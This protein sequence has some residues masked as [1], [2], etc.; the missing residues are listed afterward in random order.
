MTQSLSLAGLSRMSQLDFELAFFSSILQHHPDFLEALRAHAN[1]LRGRADMP[2]APMPTEES[3]R[4][5]PGIRSLITTSLAA[6]PF[7]ATWNGPSATS[8]MRWSPV[9]G[10][11]GF[12]ARTRTWPPSAKIRV[13]ESFSG[14]SN[15]VNLAL[16][17]M[18]PFVRVTDLHKSFG[19]G[20]TAV[21][22]L[23]KLSLDLERGE[24]V[25]LLGKSGSG[26]STLLNLL[27][28]LDHPT[29][30]SILVDGRE[31]T[32][33]NSPQ[34]ASYRL[35]HV[36]MVFQ[37][38]HL[39]TNR[40][41]L[42]NVELPMLL[43]GIPKLERRRAAADALKAVGM[44]E[45]TLHWP[46]TLSGGERQ[47]VAIARA[48]VNRPALVLADEPTGNLDSATGTV[49]MDLLIGTIQSNCSTLVLV[50][51][52]EDLARRYTDRIIHLQDGRI[53]ESK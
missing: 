39:L 28:G 20:P 8:A 40:T 4:S 6:M 23:A 2:K 38:F 16:Y 10:I 52:D 25:A 1:N 46:S 22:V 13:S 43:A 17:L 51:H 7:C 12:S 49:V 27:G 35:T 53:V 33:F 29:S 5:N 37:A 42:E 19:R 36:G 26:K 31:I 24:R 32:Q 45:R 21:S 34:R 48:L 18:T 47:R 15:A 9:I 14:N 50:T 30:G 11:S 41:A 44:G 3:S